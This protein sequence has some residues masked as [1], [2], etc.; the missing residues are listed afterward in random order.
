MAGLYIHIPFCKKACHYCNFHFSTNQKHKYEFLQAL[1]KELQQ[2]ATELKN[3]TVSSVYFGGGT[4]SLLTSEDLN[5]IFK[6][7]ETYYKIAPSAEI[8]LEANPDDL[9]NSKIKMLSETQINRLSIG[10]QSFFEEDLQL[11]N[12]AHNANE[13]VESLKIARQYFDNISIDLMYGMP[14]MSVERWRENLKVALGLGIKHMSCY[15]L[16]VE[17][18]TALEHFIKTSKHPP[19]ND[20]LAASHFQVLIEDTQKAGLTHYEVCSFGTPEYF[21]QHNTSYWLGKPYLGVGPSAHSFDGKKRSWNVSNNTTYIKTLAKNQLPLTEEILTPENR[22]NEY[23]MTGLRTMWGVS[24]R[25]IDKNYGSEFKTQLLEN[26]QKHLNSKMLIL[27]NDVLKTTNKGK[28]LC[29]GI[30]SDLFI[31]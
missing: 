22:F 6:T 29:D 12:R 24:L 5:L 28:F 14:Q 31:L 20:A 10:V 4:P 3:T 2:R 15:A 21:S 27:E 1:C 18:K 16:T 11:M 17:P 13:A 8:T 9:K 25:N 23:L 30:A 19:M 7:I 26:A